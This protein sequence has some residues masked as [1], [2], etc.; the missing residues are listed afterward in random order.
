MFT[1]FT[2]VSWILVWEVEKLI[3]HYHFVMVVIPSSTSKEINNF[4]SL[5]SSPHYHTRDECL[6]RTPLLFRKN[7]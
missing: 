5:C 1:T 4:S 2:K 6:K 7:K 3:F